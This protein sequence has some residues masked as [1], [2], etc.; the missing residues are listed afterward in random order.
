AGLYERLRETANEWFASR[1]APGLA[2]TL[3]GFHR[4]CREAGQRRG[5]CILLCYGEGG[6]N[7]PHRDIYGSVWFPLQALVV[8]SRRGRDFEGGDFVL[9]EEGARRVRR[10]VAAD[11]G[12]L[13]VF[14]SRDRPA[15]GGARV[16]L[17][18][19][20]DRVSRGERFALGIVLHLAK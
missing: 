12:D 14:A 19:G 9:F 1:Q 10:P 5:S 6:V 11:R 17:R 16:P 13:V 7:H 8:L 3:E 4:R 2:P 20:M 15:R 18:H